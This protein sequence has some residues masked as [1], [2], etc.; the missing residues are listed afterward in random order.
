MSLELKI[1][2]STILYCYVVRI[3][4]TGYTPNDGEMCSYR[5]N[6][7]GKVFGRIKCPYGDGATLAIK[8]LEKYVEYE[9]EK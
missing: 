6:V 3:S 9:K 4:P 2:E 7:D 8:M 1:N 5:L